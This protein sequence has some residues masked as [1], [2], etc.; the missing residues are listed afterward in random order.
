MRSLKLVGFEERL[1]CF[2]LIGPAPLSLRKSVF[3]LWPV[4][5]RIFPVAS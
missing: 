5:P 4:T 2:M 3:D 1:K